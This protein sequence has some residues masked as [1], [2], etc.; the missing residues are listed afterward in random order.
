[1]MCY[2]T[3]TPQKSRPATTQFSPSCASLFAPLYWHGYQLWNL[4]FHVF[5]L[6]FTDEHS[7]PVV[8]AKDLA[9]NAIPPLRDIPI[10]DINR[11]LY[12]R[13]P[14]AKHIHWR[15]FI[16]YHHSWMRFESVKSTS[17][18]KLSLQELT[19]SQSFSI[20]LHHSCKR[21]SNMWGQCG[22]QRATECKSFK[23]YTCIE[24]SPIEFMLPWSLDLS[25]PISEV[26]SLQSCEEKCWKD[27]FI[28]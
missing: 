25:V 19:Y 10:S 13:A 16:K 2:C 9:P 23:S 26:S 3:R 27:I 22:G 24:C 17:N 12:R 7:K 21:F 8:P 1:M 20:S 6:W 4:M 28:N 15:S 11:Q 14:R 18:G 5:A